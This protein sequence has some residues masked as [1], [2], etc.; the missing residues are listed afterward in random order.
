MMLCKCVMSKLAGFVHKPFRN[1]TNQVILKKKIP[2]LIYDTGNL[3]PGF[4]NSDLRVHHSGFIRIRDLRMLI[5]K[6]FFCA[7]VL[8][9]CKDS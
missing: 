4:V 8:K 6:D 2:K 5:I 1:E 3:K 7:I 9:I